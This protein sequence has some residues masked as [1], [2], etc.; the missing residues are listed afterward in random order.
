VK[1]LFKLFEVSQIATTESDILEFVD[2]EANGCA[3]KGDLLGA[4][5]WLAGRLDC[6]GSE[7]IDAVMAK[8]LAVWASSS[9]LG[10]S[11]GSMKELLSSISAFDLELLSIALISLI[12]RKPKHVLKTPALY[13]DLAYNLSTKIERIYGVN[14]SNPVE[15]CQLAAK[16]LQQAVSKASDAV[17]VFSKGQCIAARNSSIELLKSLRQLKPLVLPQECCF[18][19]FVTHFYHA[20]CRTSDNGLQ[21]ILP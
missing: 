18:S 3:D 7:G 9:E 17:G 10:L 19:R 14:S 16:R 4:G 2:G 5:E 1:T 8:N 15:L 20:V 12:A 21:K 11:P 6:A 13:R